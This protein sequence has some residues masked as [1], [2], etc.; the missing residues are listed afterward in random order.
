MQ[1][2]R[3]LD[4]CTCGIHT[5]TSCMGCGTPVCG[6]CSH[7]E[8]TTNDPKNII[9]A[10]YCPACAQDPKKNTWGTLYWQNLTALFS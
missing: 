6:R 5:E 10:Y 9:V 1:P 2:A 7:R 3:K 4:V 8:I